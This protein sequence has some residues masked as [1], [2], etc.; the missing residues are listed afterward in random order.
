MVDLALGGEYVGDPKRPYRRPLRLGARYATLPFP[1]EAGQQPTEFA[2]SIG[3][4]A[5]FAQQR[6]GVDLALEHVWRSAGDFKERSFLVS[7]GVSVKP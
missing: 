4:G 6:G 5:R 3:T 7:V 1:L 2:V